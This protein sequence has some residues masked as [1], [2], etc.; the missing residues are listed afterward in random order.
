MAERYSKRRFLSNFGATQG[1]KGPNVSG[2]SAAMGARQQALSTGLDAIQNV[3]TEKLKKGAEKRAAQNAI[4]N[5][6]YVL[7]QQ[8]EG[9]INYEDELTRKHAITKIGNDTLSSISLQ[10]AEAEQNSIMN[11]ESSAVLNN[12]ITNI[13]RDNIKGLRDSGV[14]SPILELEIQESVASSVRQTISSYAAKR[15][16]IKQDLLNAEIDTNGENAFANAGRYGDNL[17]IEK[18]NNWM[19]D[20]SDWLAKHPGK[21]KKYDKTYKVN[22]ATSFV[23]RVQMMKE[24]SPSNF[25]LRE[26]RSNIAEFKG[27][28]SE[29]PYPEIVN[30]LF[31]VE[32]QLDIYEGKSE[33]SAEDL[34]AGRS[35]ATQSEYSLSERKNYSK[36]VSIYGNI[37]DSNIM[38]GGV[39]NKRDFETIALVIED[40]DAGPVSLTDKTKLVNS[41]QK[42]YTLAKKRFEDDERGFVARGTNQPVQMI[43]GGEVNQKI[44]FDRLQDGYSLISDADAADFKANMPDEAQQQY[45][46]ISNYHK[47]AGPYKN[48]MYGSLL[49][50][51][52]TKEKNLFRMHSIGMN[53][54]DSYMT[55]EYSTNII[56][57][58]DL[59][60]TEGT[61]LDADVKEKNLA[62]IEK[63]I[64]E[65]LPESLATGRK[66]PGYKQGVLNA[67]KHYMYGKYGDV[68]VDPDEIKNLVAIFSGNET[69][70]DGLING[71]VNEFYLDKNDRPQFFTNGESIESGFNFLSDDTLP[72]YTK[73]LNPDTLQFEN[74]NEPMYGIKG[75]FETYTAGKGIT[76]DSVPLNAMK[77]KTY[78]SPRNAD[79]SDFDADDL[80]VSVSHM[81]VLE[82][83]QGNVLKNERGAPILLDLKLIG[84]EYNIR[85]ISYDVNSEISDYAYTIGGLK[86]TKGTKPIAGG[87]GRGLDPNPLGATFRD[88]ILRL[89]MQENR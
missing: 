35:N 29:N 38:Q 64:A 87:P 36:S 52:D 80:P 40:T 73:T 19:A 10:I 22:K 70:T 15:I 3:L 24:M 20:N 79:P 31:A 72:L 27:T 6:P 63:A 26:L 58:V 8:T 7:M 61:D 66:K 53:L 74:F 62:N 13:V 69:T 2:L 49:K 23:K 45:K 18:M 81:A 83:A 41:I 86:L 25:Q 78:F 68:K 28:L 48:M 34:N 55:K 5:D 47:S 56:G 77:V 17:S 9:S 4:N 57:G 75:V 46:Y 76:K 39:L 67:V 59:I 42:Y 12:K 89:R 60:K 16:K 50:K 65:I 32:T 43:T 84:Y 51:L 30:A 44:L 71:F 21:A 88:E 85:G 37:I 11:D 54:D 14:D 33:F 82:D 1:P